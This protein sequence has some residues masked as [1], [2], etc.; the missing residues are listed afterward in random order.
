MQ[1]GI[2]EEKSDVRTRVL[3]HVKDNDVNE[4]RVTKSKS[5]SMNRKRENKKKCNRARLHDAKFLEEYSATDLNMGLLEAVVLKRHRDLLVE[6]RIRNFLIQM[7]KVH[8]EHNMLLVAAAMQRIEQ[9]FANIQ[10]FL[11]RF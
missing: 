8:V 2:R 3:V 1:D 11:K 5:K 4:I 9:W 6:G 10:C 7:T